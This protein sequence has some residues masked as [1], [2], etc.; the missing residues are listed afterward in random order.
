MSIATQIRAFAALAMVLAVATSG[1]A[2]SAPAQQAATASSAGPTTTAAGDTPEQRAD[3]RDWLEALPADSLRGYVALFDE[4][5]YPEVLLLWQRDKLEGTGAVVAEARR[6]GI[7]LDVIE[8]R[9]SLDE[10][11][12]S[13]KQVGQHELALH[14]LGFVLA[15]VTC[16]RDDVDGITISGRPESTAPEWAIV[17]GP[18]SLQSP[19][20]RALDAKVVKALKDLPT[21]VTVDWEPADEAAIQTSGG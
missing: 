10:L 3:F 7:A 17:A 20:V 8:R 19:R 2:S 21:D 18:G 6:R 13:C 14:E 12:A 5:E 9:F 16:V 15:S 4:A 11:N 1:C